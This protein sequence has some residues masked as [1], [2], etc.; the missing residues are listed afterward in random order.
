MEAKP[1]KRFD[2]FAVYRAIWLAARHD[3]F[4]STGVR[5]ATGRSGDFAGHQLEG[6]LRYWIVPKRLQF[7]F[8]GLVL[9]K[10]RFMQNAP[11]A[12]AGKRTRYASFNLTASF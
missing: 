8:D 6:R 5:D 3:S 7:E 1:S 2:W 9:L 11:N 10:G 4:S 12:S